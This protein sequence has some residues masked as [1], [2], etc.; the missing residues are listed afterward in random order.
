MKILLSV[1]AFSALI[2]WGLFANASHR[3]KLRWDEAEAHLLRHGPTLVDDAR[4]LIAAR[5]DGSA[6]C[7]PQDLPASLAVPHLELARFA[8]GHLQLVLSSN[9]DSMSGYRVWVTPI[10]DDYEDH[11]TAL[12]FVKRFTFIDDYAES[13]SNRP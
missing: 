7:L 12:P 4:A 8:E 6:A 9:P 5:T 1:L 3:W 2:L 10:P 13:P 11:P